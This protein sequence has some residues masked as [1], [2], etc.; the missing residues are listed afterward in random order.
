[1]IGERARRVDQDFL[2]RAVAAL[3]DADRLL[4][5]TRLPHQVVMEGLVLELAR[6]SAR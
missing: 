2:R 6:G 3:A 5:S 4:K 1:V